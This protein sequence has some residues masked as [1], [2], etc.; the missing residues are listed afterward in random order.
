[1]FTE[2]ASV[3][4]VTGSHSLKFGGAV[5]E[6]R[7]RLVQQ[8]TGDVGIGP[9]GGATLNK[10]GILANVSQ[11]FS[12]QKINISEANC[13]AGDDGR[14]CNIFTFPCTDLAQLKTVMRALTK[15]KGVVEVER[16]W[17]VSR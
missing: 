3:S 11:A 17:A 12:A 2:S 16:T 7:W 14:A 5:S 6:G 1:M 10:P 9:S 15:V 13:R 8:W 4:Y